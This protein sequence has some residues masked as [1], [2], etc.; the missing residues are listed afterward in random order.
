MINRL[1]PQEPNPKIIFGISFGLHII[2]F[3]LLITL[4]H[5]S[6]TLYPDTPTYYVD[7][8]TLPVA[9][10]MK[11]V[12]GSSKGS[13]AESSSTP[14]QTVVKPLQ[15]KPE[16]MTI[17]RKPAANPL[18]KPSKVNNKITNK[19]E[20][21]DFAKRMEQLQQ[22]ADAQHQANAIANLRKKVAG[23]KGSGSLTG[24]GTM[25]GSD[26]ATY[27]QSRL[28]DAFATTIA[29]HSQNP[30]TAIRLY[31][32]SSGRNVRYVVEKRSSDALFNASVIKAIEK[33]KATFPKNPKGASFEML[34]VF[35][36]EKVNKKP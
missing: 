24:T 12:P 31:I 21:E 33:A 8:V 17:P 6:K 10:P 26:Y 1:Q 2:F 18:V 25:A 3:F 14:Q 32:D 30:E 5:A 27:I 34:F 4:Q 20:A 15:T 23:S 35:S 13:I 28:R 9:N 36:P 19:N 7:L 22:N 16:T 29:Y 11:G